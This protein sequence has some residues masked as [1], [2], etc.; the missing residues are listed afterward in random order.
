[1]ADKQRGGI[2]NADAMYKAGFASRSTGRNPAVEAR[3]ALIETAYD[4]I[5][6]MAVGSIKSGFR[7]LQKFR[8]QTD[9]QTALLNLRIDKMPK[10]NEDLKGSIMEIKKR[11]DK[12]A[13]KAS[14]GVGKMR[15][16]GRQDMALYMQ[17][18]TDMSS[19]LE[20]FKTSTEASQGMASVLSGV[21]GENNQAGNKNLSVSD[22]PAIRIDPPPQWNAIIH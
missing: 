12:A 10:G 15:S 9:S 21:A 17:Q 20:I 4:T 14:L 19:E 3:N 7:N 6:T 13:R 16:K 2:I 11:Y 22:L 8:N 5:G 18:L 1:M